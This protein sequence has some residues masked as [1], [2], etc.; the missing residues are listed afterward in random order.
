MS[1]DGAHIR[2]LPASITALTAVFLR[3]EASRR[4]T[5]DRVVLQPKICKPGYH[6]E[7]V[8]WTYSEA[9]VRGVREETLAVQ[10]RMGAYGSAE[11]KSDDGY[12]SDHIGRRG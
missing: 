9:A 3:I 1:V 11:Q 10:G 12:K 6:F 4:A 5:L 8:S 2:K 7:D